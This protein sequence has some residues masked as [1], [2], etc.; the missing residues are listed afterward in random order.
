VLL[1]CQIVNCVFDL[2][3][4]VRNFKRQTILAVAQGNLLA[5]WISEVESVHRD[6]TPLTGSRSY[7]RVG[8]KCLC[9]KSFDGAVLG[10]IAQPVDSLSAIAKRQPP[11]IATDGRQ[12]VAAY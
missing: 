3:S 11:A 4:L 12:I 1:S 2:D 7:I 8:P 5:P 10:G 6:L 9:G